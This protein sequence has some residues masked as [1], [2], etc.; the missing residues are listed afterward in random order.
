MTPQE[1]KNSILQLA[2]RG[3]LTAQYTEDSSVDDLI[4]NCRKDKMQAIKDGKSGVKFLK[5]L[6]VHN[7]DGS[8]K[9]EIIKMFKNKKEDDTL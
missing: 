2:F 1:L 6:Y 7:E 9:N 4:V 8:Y 3:K 5:P